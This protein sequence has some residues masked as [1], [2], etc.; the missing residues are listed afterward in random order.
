MRADS[1]RAGADEGLR[2]FFNGVR[3]GVAVHQRFAVGQ[4][5]VRH[6]FGSDDGDDDLVTADDAPAVGLRRGQRVNAFLLGRAGAV[7][8]IGGGLNQSFLAGR[9]RE[10][11]AKGP[12]PGADEV[13]SP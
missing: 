9:T 10:S 7:R 1:C 8:H 2:G 5:F 12:A 3:H 11:D 13:K 6:H 4:Q